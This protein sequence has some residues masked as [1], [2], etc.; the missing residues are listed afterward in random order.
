MSFK[1]II[2]IGKHKSVAP[3]SQLVKFA[4][5]V[6][7]LVSERFAETPYILHQ[8]SGLHPRGIQ[9]FNVYLMEEF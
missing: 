8:P 2:L 9:S 7:K 5:T 1:S 6:R 3:F 4:H